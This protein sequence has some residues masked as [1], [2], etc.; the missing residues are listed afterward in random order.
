MAW[1]SRFLPILCCFV[2]FGGHAQQYGFRVFGQDEGL[3]N[4]TV[5]S[6]LQDRHGFLW[7]GTANGLFRYDGSAFTKFSTNEGLPAAYIAAVG[8]SPDGTI[9]TVT[10][11]GPA[12]FNGTRFLPLPL[13]GNPI[14]QGHSPLAI[15]DAA[16]L[17]FAT[18]SGLF[19]VENRHGAF[20]PHRVSDGRV[21]AVLAGR[22][23]SVWFDCGAR[24]CRSGPLQPT[25]VYGPAEGVPTEPWLRFAQATDGTLYARSRTKLLR[26]NPSAKLFES[27]FPGSHLPPGEAL[28]LVPGESLA[29][30]TETGLAL[31]EDGRCR[32][33]TDANGLPPAPVDAILQDNERS[34]W[35]GTAGFGLVRW[36]GRD[37][38]EN[39]TRR[40]GL[41]R[42]AVEAVA[43]DQTGR[44]WVATGSS[45]SILGH[46]L[47]RL[48]SAPVTA[49]AARDN[50][51]W[52]AVESQ[53]LLR[54]NTQTMTAD[55]FGP[56]NGLPPLT[57]R[58]LA[59]DD[60]GA[61]W[62]GALQ[63]L[64]RGRPSPSGFRFERLHPPGANPSDYYFQV[65]P[66]ATGVWVASA[67]GLLHFSNGAWRRYGLTEGLRKERILH[68]AVHPDGSVLVSY[69]DALGVTRLWFDNSGNVR[70]VKH[71][72]VAGGMGSDRVYSIAAD[73]K[74]R[75][76]AGTDNGVDIL[77]GEVWTHQDRNDGLTWNDC[78]HAA[79][80]TEPSGGVWV[81]TTRGLSHYLAGASLTTPP[82]R[83][84][85]TS[86]GFGD[87]GPARQITTRRA[88]FHVNLAALSFLGDRRMRFRY[89]LAGIDK[90]W[91]ESTQR[92][93]RYAALP[94]G[95]YTFQAHSVSTV[96]GPSAEPVSLS[97]EILSPWWHTWWATAGA[98]LL[99]LTSL[100]IVWRM[101]MRLI[102]T[103]QR[104]LEEAVRTRTET[105]EAQ[106]EEISRLLAAAE[107]ANR[108]KS[109][110]L[111]NMS[112]EIRTPLNG[113]LGMAELLLLA[114]KLDAEQESHA[115]TLRKSALSLMGL[116]NDL[117]DIAK[118][119]AGKFELDRSPFP[120]ADCL[121]DI[122]SLMGG[123]ARE[124]GLEIKTAIDTGGL[125]VLGDQARLRQVIINL[126][127]NA[128]KFTSRGVVTIRASAKPT[129]R[130]SARIAIAV[131]DQG[132]GISPEER[133]RIFDAFEQA[134][135]TTHLEYGGTGLGLSIARELVQK[136]GGA[137]QVDSEVGRGSIFH[138]E[139]ELPLAA[140]APS[141]PSSHPATAVPPLPQNLRIL[142]CEDNL[143]N[144]KV[145]ARM[146]EM[147]G[148]SVTLARDGKESVA[149]FSQSPFDVVL[150]DLMMPEMD[151]TEAARSIR[152]FE[153]GRRTPIIALTASA[154]REDVERCLAAG[155]DGYVSKPFVQAAL[156]NEIHRVLSGA[157]AS[158]PPPFHAP[159]TAPG[160][161]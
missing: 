3:L 137:L 27:S 6:L 119:E 80:S 24:I 30:G 89:Q 127:S 140:T 62:I 104:A 37:R 69:S 91:V 88:N 79:I 55:R 16:H 61:V 32:S 22:D 98:V 4:L 31:L 15:L 128:I 82:P 154:F 95:H 40:D 155:M 81:G 44:I 148:H 46:G 67:R 147:L 10:H 29:A 65:A 51:V 11:G 77:T 153:L 114:R 43:A 47:T 134:S 129:G 124:R 38:W 54:W 2:P 138:F 7:I 83:V 133:T 111:A 68:A 84:A 48:L 25:T 73:P 102:L 110:F 13:P 151:G 36:A 42:E 26:L 145:A 87:Q 53:G 1:V 160:T 18:D 58:G 161:P 117:L 107:A 105:V 66:G 139:I 45:L 21:N 113:V 150:M 100:R 132:I 56:P 118:I 152:E 130:D 35:L 39:W 141:D 143:I 41:D 94:P 136:M 146:L 142:L 99:L 19:L 90:D 57:V 60:G 86:W 158:P 126:T 71:Y 159:S 52:T 63:G 122:A 135:K 121:R 103:R 125:V 72:S 20:E 70:G 28:Y 49:I 76:W 12:R 112:H 108:A 50:F 149:L 116:L 17:Y 8:E 92:E 144:Q 5:N 101:R 157:A 74:G 78:M 34:L 156:I 115:L 85:I 33:V 131:E 14:I 93:I 120:L 109:V 64:Y 123:L 75:I 106:K 96:S 97:F 59:A 9:W 23:G